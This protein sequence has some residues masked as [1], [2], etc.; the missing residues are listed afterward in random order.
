MPARKE[1]TSRFR[2]ALTASAGA[3]IGWCCLVSGTA[4]AYGPQATLFAPYH[5]TL[6]ISFYLFGM[7]CVSLVCIYLLTRGTAAA[8]AHQDQRP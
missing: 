5:S 4:A 2:A 7:C 6:P 8:P 3:T 1:G